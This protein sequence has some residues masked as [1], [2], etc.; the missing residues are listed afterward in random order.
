MIQHAK[1]YRQLYKD[2]KFY[3]T[4]TNDC[5]SKINSFRPRIRHHASRRLKIYRQACEHEPTNSP[6]IFSITYRVFDIF[7]KMNSISTNVIRI[8]IENVRIDNFS[9]VIVERLVIK[10]KRRFN[11]FDNT[12]FNLMNI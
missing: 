11:V 8:R 7:V 2:D 12:V 10:R 3:C 1:C 9:W 5:N 4:Y 6:I